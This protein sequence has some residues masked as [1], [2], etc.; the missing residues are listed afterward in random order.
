MAALVTAS[1]SQSMES[2]D[3]S[4][5]GPSA[6]MHPQAAFAEAAIASLPLRRVE[7]GSRPH[8]RSRGDR[9]SVKTAGAA[10]SARL[11]RHWPLLPITLLAGLIYSAGLRGTGYSP[12][13]S[14]AAR[15]MSRSWRAFVFGTVDPQGSI[16]IDKVPGFLWPQALSA[17]LFGFHPWALVLPQVVEGVICAVGV[18]VLVVG[19]FGRASAVLAALAFT[20]SPIAASAFGHT[21]EDGMLAMSLVLAAVCWQ[22]MLRTGSW[23]ALVACGAFVGLGFQAKM[24]QAWLI[25][26]PLIVVT[27]ALWQVPLRQ[28]LVRA[29]SLLGVSVVASLSWTFVIL[30]TPSSGRPFVDGSTNGDVLAMVFGYNGLGRFGIQ[31]PGALPIAFPSRGE[32]DETLTKLITADLYSQYGWLLPIAVIGGVVVFVLARRESR[33]GALTGRVPVVAMWLLWL[34]TTFAVIS[35]GHI[36]HTAYVVALVAPIAALFGAS[37]PV[38]VHLYRRGAAGWW[39]LPVAV[40]VTTLAGTAAQGNFSSFLPGAATAEAIAG[41]AVAIALVAI[42]GDRWRLRPALSTLAVAVVIALPAAWSLSVW[43]PHHN[44][45][46]SDASAGPGGLRGYRPIARARPP[47][48]SHELAVAIEQVALYR[49]IAATTPGVR[50]PLISDAWHAVAAYELDTPGEALPIGGYSHR[51]PTMSQATLV[52]LVRSG[53]ARY[54]LLS[55]SLLLPPNDVGAGPVARLVEHTCTPVLTAPGTPP[56]RAAHTHLYDCWHLRSAR[57][58]RLGAAIGHRPRTRAGAARYSRHVASH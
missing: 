3:D 34:V 48:R 11:S 25:L 18:Y 10:A 30:L 56:G 57:P 19:L 24:L 49:F 15:A 29:A 28:R 21:M 43:T 13:Y 52:R 33:A 1:P 4:P 5:G 8:P 46:A 39:V 6:V 35:V 50:Y 37:V 23:L 27:V 14:V 51:V 16:T 17:R 53:Q 26:L 36:S 58:E 12:F 44:G 9:S 41:S 45:S 31:L 40:L 22:R 54:V 20:L 55:S 2:A 32:G 42:R 7:A 38:L 47:S